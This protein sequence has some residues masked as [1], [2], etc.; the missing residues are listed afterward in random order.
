MEKIE[1]NIIEVKE[2]THH[3]YCDECGDHLGSSDECDDGYYQ[4][5]GEFELKCYTPRGWYRL[6]KCLCPSCAQERVDTFCNTLEAMGFE[7]D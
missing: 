1:T 5:F 2:I 3:F 6:K 7:R 4:R